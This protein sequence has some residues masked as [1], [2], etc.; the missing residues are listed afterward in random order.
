MR[1]TLSFWLSCLN[2]HSA[3]I[4]ANAILSDVSLPG[5]WNQYQ[6]YFLKRFFI[7]VVINFRLL[8]IIV[9]ACLHE[10]RSLWKPDP[11]NL[12]L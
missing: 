9:F 1:M 3:E 10:P 5:D 6:K 2:L 4:K 7:I 8:L 12:W 11:L